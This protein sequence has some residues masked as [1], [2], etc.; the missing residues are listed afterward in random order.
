MSGP[1]HQ[2]QH[3]SL[4]SQSSSTSSDSATLVYIAMASDQGSDHD[5]DPPPT[6][7]F[8]GG[9][10]SS[11][12]SDLHPPDRNVPVR[13]VTLGTPHDLDQRPPVRG[14]D[15]PHARSEDLNHS[16]SWGAH[17]PSFTDRAH[18]QSPSPAYMASSRPGTPGSSSTHQALPPSSSDHSESSRSRPRSVHSDSSLGSDPPTPGGSQLGGASTTTHTSNSVAST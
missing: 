7:Q 11:P 16:S 14:D 6:A 1:D 15:R 5:L 4:S 2:K 17:D 13:A 3:L 18:T 12:R 10:S 8:N 9:P